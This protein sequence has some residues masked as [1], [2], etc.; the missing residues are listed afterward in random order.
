MPAPTFDDEFDTLNLS[1][2]PWKPAISWAPNGTTDPTVSSWSVN[3][4]WGPT[5]A[6]DANIFSDSNGVLSMAVKPTPGDVKPSDVGSKP[7]RL[8]RLGRDRP[9]PLRERHRPGQPAPE[10]GG[11]DVRERHAALQVQLVDKT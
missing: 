6:A 10:P 11:G 9:Q 7:L 4:A 8:W 5:S 2:G 3:P 1:T